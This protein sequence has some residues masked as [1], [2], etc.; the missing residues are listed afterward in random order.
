LVIGL[1]HPDRGD[2]ALGTLVADR[3][4][5]RA[6]AGVSVLALGETAHLLDVIGGADT[7]VIV[8]AALS[9]APPGTIHRFDAHAAALP[10]AMFAM[11]T[12]AM[13]LAEAIE[14]ARAL[15][16]L[17]DRCIVYAVEGASFDLGRPLSPAVAAA[18]DDVIARVLDEVGE[19]IG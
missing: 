12:H 13:G 18:V 9:G 8:D 1:G 11:S 10:Q 4:S 7:V 19:R 3:L 6:P 17:P 14:L 15:D 16:L 5:E 2:D